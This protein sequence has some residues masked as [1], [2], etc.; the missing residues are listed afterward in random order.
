MLNQEEISLQ[1]LKKDFLTYKGTFFRK[2]LLAGLAVTLLSI[3]QA[4]AYSIVVGLPPSCGL[5]AIIFGTLLCALFGSSRYLIAGP[6]NTIVMLVQTATAGILLKY[7]PDVGAEKTEVALKVMSALLLLIA[8]FELLAGLFKLG[9]VIQF[10]SFP[11]VLGYILGASCALIIIQLYTLLGV[12]TWGEDRTLFERFIHL[13]RNLRETHPPT[14]FVG[15]MSLTIYLTLRKLHLKAPSSLVMLLLVTSLVYIYGLHEI[16]VPQGEGKTIS[17]IGDAGKVEAVIP[18][19]HFPL[20]DLRLLN[21]LFPIALA[22]ALI[23]MLETSSI[24]KSISANS[25]ERFY[26]NQ[27]LFGLGISNFVLSLFGALPS[28]GSISRTNLNYESGAMTRFAA[29]FSAF[30]VAI[31]VFFFGDLIQYIPLSALAA[32]IVA[33]ALRGIDMRQLKLC[34]RATHS[35]ACVLLLTFFSCFFFSLHIAFYIGVAASCMLYLRKAATP[36]VLEYLVDEEQEEWRPMLDKENHLKKPIRL[37][38]VEGELFFGAVDLFR[39]TLKAIA[40]DDSTTKVIIIRLKHVRDFD[41]TAAMA[42]KQLV[43]YLRKSGRHLIVT[44]IPPAVWEVIEKAKLIPYIGK[45]NLFTYDPTNPQLSVLAAIR[46][47]K[48]F[49]EG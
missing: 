20:F 4:I 9:R 12:E 7:Y 17:V 35:D 21:T 13:V 38:D 32:L 28:S 3:P 34:L 24:A 30:F 11:V 46:R 23:S 6:T 8:L 37:I 48:F 29:I 5:I 27:E 33:T 36:R 25:G 42:L 19:L 18:S 43:D 26:A 47:A 1:L 49:L 2:D 16:S 31:L 14:A 45:D 40:E 39:W 44:S 22:I 10:V 41:A 15:I